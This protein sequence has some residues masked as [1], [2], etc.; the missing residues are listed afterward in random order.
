MNSQIQLNRLDYGIKRKYANQ[1]LKFGKASNY[2]NRTYLSHIRTWNSFIEDDKRNK[3]DFINQYKSILEN[4][5]TKGYEGFPAIQIT[6]E[7]NLVNGIH[8]LAGCDELGI[9]PKIEYVSSPY[10]Y[11]AEFFMTYRNPHDRSSFSKQLRDQLV[12][13]YIESVSL[14]AIIV[15]PRA[16][17]QDGG[18][19]VT[20]M[21]KNDRKVSFVQRFKIPLNLLNLMV[22]HFYYDQRWCNTEFGINW[23]AIMYKTK[24]IE[25]PDTIQYLDLYVTNYTQEELAE[26]KKDIRA[27]YGIGNSSVHSTDKE[28]D[29][30]QV[31]QFLTSIRGIRSLWSIERAAKSKILY[32]LIKELMSSSYKWNPDRMIVGSVINDITGLREANDIDYI[33]REDMCDGGR[34]SSNASHNEYEYL[35]SRTRFD[36]LDE[37]E[38]YFTLFGSKIISVAE[39]KSFKMQRYEEKDYLDLQGLSSIGV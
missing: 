7:Q 13:A 1:F 16:I 21:M 24:E 11:N 28:K 23:E 10:K 19:F 30:R 9:N 33:S 18:K 14:N 32:Y 25:S 4:L 31:G 3:N 38:S 26:I 29:T 12:S 22:A 6:Q 34:H 35:Y 15:L 8:R 17:A 20:H 39:Y 27:H 5:A 2:T 37:P 36:L